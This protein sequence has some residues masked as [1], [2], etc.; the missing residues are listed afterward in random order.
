MEEMD[1]SVRGVLVEQVISG[2][3]VCISGDHLIQQYIW[4]CFGWTLPNS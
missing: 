3:G 1:E 4:L 2:G